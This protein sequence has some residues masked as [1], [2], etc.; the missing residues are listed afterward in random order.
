MPPRNMI[1]TSAGDN[2]DFVKWWCSK[3][4]QNYDIYVYYYGKNSDN[5][6][7]YEKNVTHIERSSGSKFQNFYKFW[8]KYP[9][10]INE[11]DRFFILDDDIEIRYEDINKMFNISREYN[12]D[13]CAPCFTPQSKISHEVTKHRPNILLSYTNLVE[14]NTPL[15]SRNALNKL[16][17]VYDP[18]LIGWGIDILYIWANGCD[19]QKSY[20][21]VHSIQCTN[22]KDSLKRNKIRELEH[23]KD[24]NIRNVIWN[25][26]SKK[27][28]CPQMFNFKNHSDIYLKN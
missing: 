4:K 22:P 16:M 17:K 28:N 7:L 10:V 14:V 23:I 21:I 3:D 6:A 26:F 5:F 13:I 9:E 8:N 15:F 27:I 24:C 19:R 11:Y 20:A 12:L 2:T 1:F 18:V 25:N